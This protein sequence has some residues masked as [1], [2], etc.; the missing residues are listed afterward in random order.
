MN[1]MQKFLTQIDDSKKLINFFEFVKPYYN[2]KKRFYHNLNHITQCLNSLKKISHHISQNDLF[3]LAFSIIGHD[4]IMKKE[5][6]LTP[7]ELSANLTDKWCI[8]NNLNSLDVK[9]IKNCIL[10]TQH[11]KKTQDMSEIEKM[12]VSIDLLILANENYDSYK[13]SI[14]KEIQSMSKKLN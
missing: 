3:C 4:V 14:R 13:N 8:E 2:D 7:E 12:M 11:F 6:N 9:K 10:A 1:D 5:D